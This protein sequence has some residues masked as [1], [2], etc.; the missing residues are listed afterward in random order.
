MA[1]H[2]VPEGLKTHTRLYNKSITQY[3][4]VIVIGSYHDHGVLSFGPPPGG[5]QLT[6]PNAE[7]QRFYLFCCSYSR[8]PCP[9]VCDLL[10][11]ATNLLQ[12]QWFCWF[13]ICTQAV[14]VC[15]ICFFYSDSFFISTFSFCLFFLFPICLL[16][17]IVCFKGIQ[18]L[19]MKICVQI[20]H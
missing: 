2:V 3:G 16:V 19:K 12:T 7:L 20:S 13:S 18:W 17:Q 14:L 11:L 4:Q 9:V 10:S 6:L 5:A 15:S 1:L 8:D